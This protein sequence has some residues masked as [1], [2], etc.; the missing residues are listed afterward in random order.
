[1]RISYADIGYDIIEHHAFIPRYRI[2]C[3]SASKT[4]LLVE[5]KHRSEEKNEWLRHLQVFLVPVGVGGVPFDS[6]AAG[7]DDVT[8]EDESVVCWAG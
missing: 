2:R 4:R 5:S 1:M 8:P 6:D 7:F 3:T